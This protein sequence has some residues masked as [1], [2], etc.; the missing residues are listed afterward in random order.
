MDLQIKVA[1]AEW[2]AF[3]TVTSQNIRPGVQSG[4]AAV[5][6]EDAIAGGVAST[7]GLASIESRVAEHCSTDDWSL[8]AWSIRLRRMVLLFGLYSSPIGAGLPVPPAKVS[9]TTFPPCKMV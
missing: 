5:S 9:V 8:L 4:Q 1:G 2:I 6:S 3:V 7:Y